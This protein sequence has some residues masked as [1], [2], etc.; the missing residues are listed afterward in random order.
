MLNIIFIIIIMFTF[1]EKSYSIACGELKIR[2]DYDLTYSEYPLDFD[3]LELSKLKYGYEDDDALTFYPNSLT[4][5]FDDFEKKYYDVLKLSLGEYDNNFPL[6][7]SKYGGVILTLN[8]V[9]K[10]KGYIDPLTLS[11][12]D[13]SR[14]VEFECID[15]SKALRDMSVENVLDGNN[16][17]NLPYLVYRIYLK[18]FPELE[19][20]IYSSSSFP[21]GIYFKHDWQ[22]TGYRTLS[23]Y[24]T[25]DWAVH[26]DVVRTYFDFDSAGLFSENRPADTYADLL[27]LLALQFGMV[28]GTSDLNKI[29]MAKRFALNNNN[30][31]N[32]DLKLIG[33]YKK[34]L[35]LPSLVGV[36]VKNTWGN[37]SRIFSYG[38]V[39]TVNSRGDLKYKNI[40]KDFDT[41]IAS[42]ADLSGGGSAIYVESNYP[43]FTDIRDPAL[44]QA[45]HIALLI[46]KWTY[47]TRIRP[48][49]KIE[50]EAS[51]IDYVLYK[52]YEITNPGNPTLRFR[53]M[54]IEIDLLE[55]KSSLVGVEV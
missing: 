13:E 31:E 10:F 30:F 26:N 1:W 42:Y 41:Y 33:T 54:E 55:D 7:F 32:L 8:S 19:P 45:D 52:F 39:E 21:N 34:Y 37:E 18:V 15:I 48:K 51:G 53:P 4:L 2:I 12:D 29:Y 38:S 25:R 9:A 11:Y 43:V 49:D 27:K 40:V 20:Y 28:I 5:K 44:N 22:F 17:R 36:R 16:L 3:V 46:A 14:T 47:L 50:C 24:I 23:D 35:H 6:N